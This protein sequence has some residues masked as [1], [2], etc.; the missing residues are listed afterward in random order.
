MLLQM[1]K[2]HPFY[3][4][5]SI[6]LC[7]HVCIYISHIHLLMDTGCFHIFDTVNNAAINIGVHI[8]F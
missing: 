2:F 8:G 6:P 1:A 3:S 5:S 7:I 4:L